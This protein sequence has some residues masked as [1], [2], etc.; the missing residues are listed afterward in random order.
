MNYLDVPY[1]C[2]DL[3]KIDKASVDVAKHY[4]ALEYTNSKNI[5]TLTL[6]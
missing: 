5:E 2:Y 1:C 6:I 4:I 3:T